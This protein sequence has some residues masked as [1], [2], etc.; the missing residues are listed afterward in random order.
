[1][2]CIELPE[3][4]KLVSIPARRTL[5]VLLCCGVITDFSGD[6]FLSLGVF[7]FF[8]FKKTSVALLK[9]WGVEDYSDL[10]TPFPRNLIIT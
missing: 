8:I 6:G 9:L 3:E 1:M 5:V 10:G 4:S 7:Y 2:I